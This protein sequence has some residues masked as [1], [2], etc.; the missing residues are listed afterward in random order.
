MRTLARASDGWRVR[1]GAS[2]KAPAAEWIAP[3]RGGG[4][5][6]RRGRVKGAEERQRGRW[7]R[8]EMVKESR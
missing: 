8:E 1:P 5:G 4:E 3:A 6:T 7:P 2:V